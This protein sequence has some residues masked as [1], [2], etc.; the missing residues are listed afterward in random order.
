M[1]LGSDERSAAASPKRAKCVARAAAVLHDGVAPRATLFC[2]AHYAPPNHRART[3]VF[4]CGAKKSLP[5]RSYAPR[6]QNLVI[7]I[8]VPSSLRLHARALRAHIE[9]VAARGRQ[10]HGQPLRLQARTGPC[11]PLSGHSRPLPAPLRHILGAIKRYL[12][13]PSKGLY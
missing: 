9:G 11:K 5:P 3:I 8:W 13:T 2:A 7:T 4:A 12:S 1:A 10:R 6:S